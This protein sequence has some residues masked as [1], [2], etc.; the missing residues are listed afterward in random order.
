MYEYTLTSQAHSVEPPEVMCAAS[1]IE[2]TS[3][4]I[5]E[6]LPPPLKVIGTLLYSEDFKTFKIKTFS[7]EWE[8]IEKCE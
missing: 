2:Q 8:E 4:Q 3:E 1:F 5:D 6:L 7:G